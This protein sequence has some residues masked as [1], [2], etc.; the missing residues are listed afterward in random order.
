MDGTIDTR[1]NPDELGD[2]VDPY[3][4]WMNGDIDYEDLSDEDKRAA[5]ALLA[6]AERKDVEESEQQEEGTPPPAV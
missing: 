4:A 1:T 2:T 5:D 3:E 6:Y